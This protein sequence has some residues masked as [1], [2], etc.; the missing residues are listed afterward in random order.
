MIVPV[1]VVEDGGALAF[2][3]AKSALSWLIRDVRYAASSSVSFSRDSRR[4]SVSDS[5]PGSS[6][7]SSRLWGS[8]GLGIGSW[9]V[10]EV[11]ILVF[12]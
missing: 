9:F 7:P 2:A 3:E 12:N 5:E 10:G 11:V 4:A 8:E 6:G 1:P